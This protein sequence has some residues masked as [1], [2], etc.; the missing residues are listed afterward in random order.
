[1]GH[2]V[3]PYGFRLG[4]SRTW[5]AKWYRDKEYTELLQEDIAGGIGRGHWWP[6]HQRRDRS[7]HSQPHHRPSEPRAQGDQRPEQRAG[8][9][10][11]RMRGVVGRGARESG[12]DGIVADIA[13]PQM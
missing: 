12:G 4:V 8:R 10:A 3:H 5:T 6:P 9:E 13:P 7:E 1:M 2:K 11:G